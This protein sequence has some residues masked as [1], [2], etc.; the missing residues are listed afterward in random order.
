MTHDSNDDWYGD[1]LC[2]QIGSEMFFPD[3]GGSTRAAKTICR[4]CTVVDACLVSALVR[5]EQ[6]GIWGGLSPRERRQLK[7]D[8]A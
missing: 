3:K 4:K 2:A 8:A 1:A 6:H 5:D 7:K